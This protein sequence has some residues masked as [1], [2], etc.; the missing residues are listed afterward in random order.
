MNCNFERIR[1]NYSFDVTTSGIDHNATGGSHEIG[2][3]FRFGGGEA[4]Y[5]KMHSSF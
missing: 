2:L 4:G 5:D 1:F 3:I